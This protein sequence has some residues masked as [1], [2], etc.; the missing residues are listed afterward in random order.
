MKAF[1][2]IAAADLTG[3]ASPAG[4]PD[5]RALVVA[6]DDADAKRTV[7]D[8]IDQFGFDVVDA[9]RS[10]RAGASSGTPPVRRPLH[11]R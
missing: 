2:H 4:T 11:R 10:R 9:V 8:L 6:G 5:R 3:H 1:N 7:S